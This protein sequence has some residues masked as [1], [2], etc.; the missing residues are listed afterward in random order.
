MIEWSRQIRKKAAI[1]EQLTVRRT[2]KKTDKIMNACRNTVFRMK[3]SLWKPCFLMPFFTKKLYIYQT[4]VLSH[5]KYC[6]IMCKMFW[7]QISI[8]PL[9][10]RGALSGGWGGCLCQWELKA[11]TDRSRSDCVH[12]Q[13]AKRIANVRFTKSCM[14]I[15]KQIRSICIIKTSTAKAGIQKK[16]SCRKGER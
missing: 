3:V 14:I 8:P 10:V 6:G 16:K 5:V 2:V 15:K 11:P 12:E 9:Q 4:T 1:N 7:T 13:V